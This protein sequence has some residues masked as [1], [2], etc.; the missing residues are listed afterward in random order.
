MT[1]RKKD[2]KNAQRYIK[3]GIGEIRGMGVGGRLPFSLIVLR[4]LIPYCVFLSHKS[5]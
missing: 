3:C 1:T 5:V 4:L 2:K